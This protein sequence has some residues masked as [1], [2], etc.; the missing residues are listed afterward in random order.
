KVLEG[1]KTLPLSSWEYKADPND[2]RY[3]GP[4]A[5]DFQ[6]AFGLGD[7]KTINTLDA[8]G[9]LFA[10]VQALAKE[11]ERIAQENEDLRRRIE[12]LEKRL[13]SQQ[14]GAY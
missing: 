11:N 4:M 3:I 5:Q 6:A 1:V 7:D 10:A 12:E 14:N 8:D 2:R 9:V 13:S